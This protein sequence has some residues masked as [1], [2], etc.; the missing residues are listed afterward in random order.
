MQNFL[1]LPDGR[2]LIA[3]PAQAN[4]LASVA[5]FSVR[6]AERLPAC[7]KMLDAPVARPV[8][9]PADGPPIPQTRRQCAARHP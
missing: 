6:D 5:S 3:G 7:Y 1:P 8:G 4:T 9:C 2:A